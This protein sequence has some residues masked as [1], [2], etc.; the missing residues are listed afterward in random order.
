[1]AQ[2][3]RYAQI[4]EDIFFAKY[5]PGDVIVPFERVEIETTATKLNIDLPKNL[6]DIVY[7]FKFRT[8]LPKNIR[9]RGSVRLKLMRFMLGWIKKARIMY[10]QYRQKAAQTK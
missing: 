9:E 8:S 5:N 6:G 3:N 1:M 10:F 4:I 2:T 7:S